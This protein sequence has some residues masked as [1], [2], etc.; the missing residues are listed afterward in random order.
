MFRNVEGDIGVDPARPLIAG[1]SLGIESRLHVK[2]QAPGQP[3]AQATEQ[4]FEDTGR[5]AF[6]R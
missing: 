4:I 6:S 2:L 5:V 3:A 1:G